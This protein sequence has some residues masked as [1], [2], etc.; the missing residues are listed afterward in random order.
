MS[1]GFAAEGGIDIALTAE[2]DRIVDVAIVNCRP[3]GIASHLVGL[4]PENALRR[5]TS[6]FSVCRIAQGIAGSMAVERALGIDPGP[7]QKA[8]R[9]FL[10]RGETALEHATCALLTWPALVEQIPSGFS[11]VKALRGALAELWHSIYA[12]GDWMRPGG[13]RLVPDKTALA[14]NLAGAEAAVQKAGLALPLDLVGWRDWLSS[15]DGPAGE[16]LRMLEARDWASCGVSRVA[17]LDRLS[18]A[19]IE[20]HLSADKNG[21]FIARPEWEGVVWETGPLARRMAEPVIRE[22][23]AEHGLGLAARFLAQCVETMRCL[24]EMREIMGE[25]G[26]DEGA[27][28]TVRDGEGLGCVQAVRGWL[29][30]RVEIADGRISRYQILAPTEWN[31][32]PHGAFAR[33]LT[34]SRP[35]PPPERLAQLMVAALDPCVPCQIKVCSQL[36]RKIF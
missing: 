13:G 19:E 7:S 12:D 8:A 20:Q 4:A 24:G 9:A 33:G 3:L 29:V 28:V 27:A 1:G 2:G 14:A 11:I 22:A 17:L 18:E 16:L 36:E 5:V 15:A 30:H 34:K 10:L 35:G 6:V 31:F 32:H 25:M 21:A 26:R 23:V